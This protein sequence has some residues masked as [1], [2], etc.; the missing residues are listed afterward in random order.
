MQGR[1][2]DELKILLS[3]LIFGDLTGEALEVIL[4]HFPEVASTDQTL[5]RSKRVK[6]SNQGT[7]N[8]FSAIKR[9]TIVANKAY[10]VY[11]A[12]KVC[13]VWVGRSCKR[14]CKFLLLAWAAWQLQFSPSACGTLRKHVTKPCP[15]PAAPDCSLH[16]TVSLIKD[17]AC[18]VRRKGRHTFSVGW[19][20][21]RLESRAHRHHHCHQR[22]RNR[23]RSK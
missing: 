7:E 9:L 20:G 6:P 13:P 15:Q 18:L 11:P 2:S 16:F 1:S 12:C 3:R 21:F 23:L 14:F 5:Q 4:G 22:N 8:S 17:T 19:L 10:S